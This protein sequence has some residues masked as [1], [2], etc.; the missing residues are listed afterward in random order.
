MIAVL[1]FYL[2]SGLTAPLWA[3]VVLLLIWGL[4]FRLAFKWFRLHPFRVVVLPFIAAAIWFGVMV[5]GEAVL[6]W[7]A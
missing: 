1:P 7:T 2:E 3:I 5:A 4:L 6:G